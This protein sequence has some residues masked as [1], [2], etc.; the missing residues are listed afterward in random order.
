MTHSS[1]GETVASSATLTRAL[2]VL[3]TLS[4]LMIVVQGVTAGQ[5]L[6]RDR[7][8]EAL[9]SVGAIVVHVLT[10]LTALV[11][12][13]IAR[14]SRDAWWLTGIAVV[15]FI[16][17]FIQAALGDAGIL[18]VHVPL[19]MLLLVGAATVMIWSFRWVRT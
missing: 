3:A 2:S 14:R 13:L 11:A 1:A 15:V 8:A 5:I 4:V 10:G 6:S 18:S 16:V 7:G 9:H 19:A 17:T 12:I